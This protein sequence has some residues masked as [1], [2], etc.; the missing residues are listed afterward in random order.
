M[1][2]AQTNR[3]AP[4]SRLVK[5]NLQAPASWQDVIP[6]SEHVLDA[7]AVGGYFFARYMVDAIVRVSSTL[8]T[9]KGCARSCC[10]ALMLFRGKATDRVA[11]YSFKITKLPARCSDSI[12]PAASSVYRASNAD[13]DSTGYVSKQVFYSSKDGTRVPV[14]IT[15]RADLVRIKPI[16]P[17]C[18]AMVV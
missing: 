3:A 2:Y 9:G 1:L 6:E 8:S 7:S 13:F 4:N 5:F 12:W 15:H 10:R 18:T 16:P 11:Y 17:Y 14:I